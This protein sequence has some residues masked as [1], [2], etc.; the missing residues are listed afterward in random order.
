MQTIKIYNRIHALFGRKSKGILSVFF[1]AGYPEKDSTVAIALELANAGVD[2]VEIGMPF[3]DPLADGPVIQESSAIAIQNGTNISLIFDQVREIRKET[4]IPI[5][6]MGYLNPVMRYGMERF[7]HDASLVGI[8]GCIL[9]DLP[10]EEYETRYKG[11]FEKYNL[12]YIPLVTPTTDT[13]R[14]TWLDSLASGFIYAV[15]TTAITGGQSEGYR[16]TSLAYFDQLSKMGLNNPILAGFGIHNK[17]TFD[18][19]CDRLNGGIIGTAFIRMLGKDNLKKRI[20][21]F[22]ISISQKGYI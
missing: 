21:E 4:D 17:L 11:L 13:E 6:L 12:S 18:Q 1:T 5:L 16:E 20:K 8:D 3:S 2:M 15:S 19:V 10:I 22:I 14:I 9:P 7:L